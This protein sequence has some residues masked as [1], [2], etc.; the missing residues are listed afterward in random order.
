[1]IINVR[2]WKFDNHAC[3]QQKSWF[4]RLLVSV[5]ETSSA[6]RVSLLHASFSIKFLL[7]FILF[8]CLT[9]F[10]TTESKGGSKI[11]RKGAKNSATA[12]KVALMK[13][14]LH[15][16]GDKGLPQVKFC[17]FNY[18]IAKWCSLWHNRLTVKKNYMSLWAIF[19]Y[20]LF[21]LLLLCRPKEPSFRCIFQ[22]NL[23]FPAN[24]CSFA[25]NGV[26]AKW[27]IMQ[28]L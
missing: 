5:I 20:F 9:L 25:P 10:F 4:K 28:L 26:S 13:L 15:A 22:K 6:H 27:W 11:G 8:C 3:Q 2:S 16:S 19:C 24:P 1:M 18:S 17:Q 14:K 12:A 23:K 21:D 7:V